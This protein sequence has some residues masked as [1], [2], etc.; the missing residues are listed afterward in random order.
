MATSQDPLA[1]QRQFCRGHWKKEEGEED[2]RRGG[3]ITSKNGQEWGLEIF[4]DHHALLVRLFVSAGNILKS[5]IT[6]QLK[7]LDLSSSAVNVQLS[8]AQKN[9]DKI[10]IRISLTLDA[11]YMFLSLQMIFSGAVVCA[12]LGRIS[13]FD[14]LLE[15]ICPR[16]LKLSAASSLWPFI[17]ISHWKQFG[18]MS[19][20]SLSSCL[21]ESPSCTM[22]WFIEAVY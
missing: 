22:W 21:D 3:K 18:S 17:L 12:I 5:P 11:G 15:M 13:G 7:G 16:Y 2:R 20:S 4:L 10:S 9:V 8:Q 6:S 1:W 19:F 14:P